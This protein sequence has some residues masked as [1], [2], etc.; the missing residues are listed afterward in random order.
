MIPYDERGR[1][2]SLISVIGLHQ[3]GGVKLMPGIGPAVKRRRPRRGYSVSPMGCIDMEH[4]TAHKRGFFRIP[5]Y[6][7]TPVKPDHIFD[8][9]IF[10][11]RN[12][13][14]EVGWSI[15]GVKRMIKIVQSFD[16]QYRIGGLA[17]K[18]ANT[19]KLF[20]QRKPHNPHPVDYPIHYQATWTDD[21]PGRKDATIRIR[22]YPPE[23]KN[24]ISLESLPVIEGDG[25]VMNDD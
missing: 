22:R 24:F 11:N 4:L 12:Q 13:I 17:E 23:L 25:G 5:G 21:A 20:V 10:L 14:A 7:H 6:G 2:N 18:R 19:I 8:L 15:A 3:E 1:R 16:P 9:V